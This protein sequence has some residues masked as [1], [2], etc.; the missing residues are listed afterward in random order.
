MC[1]RYTIHIQGDLLA[2]RFGVSGPAPEASSRYNAA[3]LQNLPVVRF[4]AA[5][6]ERHLS[7]LRWGLVPSWAKDVSIGSKMINARGETLIE[8]PAFRAAFKKRRCLIPADAFYELKKEGSGKQPYAI[9]K[10]DDGPFAMAG[11]WEGWKEP[12]TEEW[13]HTFTIVTTSANPLLADL[14][15]RMPVILP[16]SRWAAWLGEDD[17]SEADLVGMLEPFAA[18]QMR[19][20]SVSRDVGNVRN[21][22]PELL[23]ALPQQALL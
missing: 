13:L 18:E 23:E 15:D 10:T 21:D 4:N 2:G 17:A 1:G 20:W 7:L 9:G 11:L 19:M 8:K 16:S 12:A 6:G 14:H 22:R 3:P 5:D